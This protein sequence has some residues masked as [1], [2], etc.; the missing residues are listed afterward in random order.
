VTDET[1]AEALTHQ[2]S[3]VVSH[4]PLPFRPL[5]RITTTTPEGRCL[6]GL[7]AAG[8]A[9]YSPH[10]A[11]DSAV[12]G[13]NQQWASALKL[14][15]VAPLAVSPDGPAGTGAGRCGKAASGTTLGTL[16]S[17]VKQFLRI[18]HVQLVGAPERTAERVGIACGSAGELHAAARLA[19]CDCLIT[20]EAR[21]HACLEALA[22]DLSLILVGHYASERFG[23]EQLAERLQ[24]EFPQLA[25]WAS[26][27]ERD[28]LAWH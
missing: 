21:F 26:R 6:L 25:V 22:T 27:D 8:I 14:T 1:V 16:A 13:I 11:F 20:G 2:A 3:L 4:H 28:P 17:Q 24:R 7:A 19:R 12:D 10:T 23:V 15:D 9:I 18:S 5:A